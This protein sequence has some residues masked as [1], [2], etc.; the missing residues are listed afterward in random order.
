MIVDATP[1]FMIAREK[2]YRSIKESFKKA[3]AKGFC[4]ANRNW[5]IGYKLH[6]IIFD[7]DIGQQSGIT[8]GI[9]LDVNY[10]KEIN[11]L[12]PKKNYWVI[13]HTLA[14]HY[15]LI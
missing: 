15:N 6:V 14:K 3:G 1:V 8:K 10:L 13:E 5:F 12:P 7:N 4:A 9:I 11:Q 2:S